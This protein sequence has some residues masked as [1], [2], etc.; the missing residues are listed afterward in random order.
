MSFERAYALGRKFEAV[1]LRTLN[2]DFIASYKTAP[3]RYFPDWDVSVTNL[4][5]KEVTFESKADTYAARTKAIA[6]EF[7]CRGRP[8][9]I[10]TTKAR[11][12]WHW[13]V[14]TRDYYIIPTS[15][16]REMIRECKFMTIKSG[17]DDGKSELYIFDCEDLLEYKRDLPMDADEMLKQPLPTRH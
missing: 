16:L 10:S 1:L 6:V 7:E 2:W 9:G 8:S 14:G 11:Y 17:G 4:S 12:W 5:G 3:S 13:V 15:K